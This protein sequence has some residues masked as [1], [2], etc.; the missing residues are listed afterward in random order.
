MLYI[1]S[2]RYTYVGISS[3]M[4]EI[5]SSMQVL[6]CCGTYILYKLVEIKSDRVQ[7]PVLIVTKTIL[8]A[9][10]KS[11]KNK[12]AGYSLAKNITMWSF[13]KYPK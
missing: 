7:H 4:S 8:Y 3:K 11:I 2:Y 1:Y 10:V 13:G 9:E 5:S 6:V 12:C